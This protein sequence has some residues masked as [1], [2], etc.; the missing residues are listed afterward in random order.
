MKDDLTIEEIVKY[1]GL[2]A[3]GFECW[4]C[5]DW[6]TCRPDKLPLPFDDFE[7]DEYYELLFDDFE[8]DDDDEF[9]FE[10]F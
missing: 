10:D 6:D 9:L 5:P 2:C 1:E 8:E 4:N 7:E 3:V